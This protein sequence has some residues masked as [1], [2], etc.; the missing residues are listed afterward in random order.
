M[1]CFACIGEISGNPGLKQKAE[2]F[3]AGCR[4]QRDGSLRSQKIVGATGRRARGQKA[5]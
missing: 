2:R 3:A 4:K 5:G 1:T